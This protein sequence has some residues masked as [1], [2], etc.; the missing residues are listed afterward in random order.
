MAKLQAA[1]GLG[2]AQELFLAIVNNLPKAV[3]KHDDGRA[4]P[5]SETRDGHA[6]TFRFYAKSIWEDLIYEA[7]RP[8]LLWLLREGLKWGSQKVTW[9]MLVRFLGSN[10][11]EEHK[12]L[13]YESALR[14]ASTSIQLHYQYPVSGSDTPER[15]KQAF[16]FARRL[17]LSTKEAGVR[18]GLAA[19]DAPAIFEPV[20]CK[21][22]SFNLE[23]ELL[24]VAQRA[25]N[26]RTLRFE[27]ISKPSPEVHPLF[28][29]EILAREV[30]C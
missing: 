19:K 12:W 15:R 18:E 6:I 14:I 20:F 28:P 27:G 5:N 30:T 26:R 23:P 22:I 10:P 29:A 16:A 17:K 9:E 2:E 24:I 13:L 8:V 1:L 4:Q 25:F 7:D 3:V 21:Q 11:V